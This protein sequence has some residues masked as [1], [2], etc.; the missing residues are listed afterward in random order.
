MAVF[1]RMSLGAKIV[2]IGILLPSILVG[3]LVRL[4][5]EDSKFRTVEAVTDEARAVCLISESIRDQMEK[6]WEMSIFYLDQI[7]WYAKNNEMEKVLQTIPVFTAMNALRESAAESGYTFK[8]PKFQPRNPVNA[9]DAFEARV[10][11]LIK[12]RDLRDY[13]EIDREMNA[14]RYFRPV[15]LTK[16]CLLC[17]GDPSG[18]SALWGNDE[19]LDLTGAKMEGWK[20][21]QIHGAFEIIQSLDAADALLNR[22]VRNISG[23]AAIGLVLTGLAF[24]L[25]VIPMVSRSVVRPVRNMIEKITAGSENLFKAARHIA[26]ASQQLAD[27]STTQ[28]SS[29]EES[30]SALE[31]MTAMTQSNADNVRQT[32]LAAE[33]MHASVKDADRRTEEM[34]EVMKLIRETSEHTGEIIKRIDDIAFQTQLLALNANIEAARA[35]EAGDGFRVVADEVRTLSRH[36]AEAAREISEMLSLSEERSQTGASFAE[37]LRETLKRVVGEVEA[38]NQLAGEIATSSKEQAEGVRQVNLGVS[39]VDKVVQ[40]N[41]AISEE[42]ASAGEEL[43]SQARSLQEMVGVLKKIVS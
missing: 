28:A 6:K 23:M 24:A 22:V 32:H 36:S 19:G 26:D 17:H 30:A 7:I 8:V 12:E 13:Y 33:R 31:E 9:P 43:S 16:T 40:A 25:I 41:A 10:L 29:V 42:V 35:G 21:G 38:V 27:G 34:A 37:T 18:S 5:V 15:R 20:E 4:Y 39:E 2:L 11:K 3:L 14:V 1:R